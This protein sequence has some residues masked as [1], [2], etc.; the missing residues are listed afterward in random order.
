MRFGKACGL[1][2]SLLPQIPSPY[3]VDSPLDKL[4]TAKKTANNLPTGL[5][6]AARL[7]TT[8]QAQ[9]AASL[10]KIGFNI[11][12]AYTQWLPINPMFHLGW[13]TAIS[14]SF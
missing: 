14:D 5:T 4:V 12:I 2:D 6:T 10:S 1:V 9:Q 8:P 7:T 13:F 11:K 3:F